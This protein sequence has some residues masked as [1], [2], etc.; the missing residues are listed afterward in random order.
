MSSVWV[1]LAG[2]K[3]EIEGEKLDEAAIR[4]AVDE[5]GYA[6]TTITGA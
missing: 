2:K 6:V 5:A 1:D 4:A 3:A